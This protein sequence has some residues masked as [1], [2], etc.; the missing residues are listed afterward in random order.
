LDLGAFMLKSPM[1][2]DAWVQTPPT[3]RVVLP[4]FF[5]R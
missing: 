2:Q 1:S 3:I 5:S 4:F